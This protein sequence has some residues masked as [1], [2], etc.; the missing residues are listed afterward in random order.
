MFR[1]KEFNDL[2][3]TMDILKQVYKNQHFIIKENVIIYEGDSYND[4]VLTL[5][6]LDRYG[7]IKI[8]VVSLENE[9]DRVTIQAADAD[10]LQQLVNQGWPNYLNIKDKLEKNGLKV[11][12]S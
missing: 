11:K 7:V 9:L 6:A 12:L 10:Q 3:K 5:L 8:S 4:P 1:Q 2:K